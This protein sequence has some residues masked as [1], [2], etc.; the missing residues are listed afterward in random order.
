MTLNQISS[1]GNSL[2]AANYKDWV[3]KSAL[4]L[5]E[6]CCLNAENPLVPLESDVEPITVCIFAGFQFE[7]VVFIVKS[8]GAKFRVSIYLHRILADPHVSRLKNDLLGF[9]ALMLC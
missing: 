3:H 2:K 6:A 5:V 9:A 8:D 1:Q 4:S 7:F